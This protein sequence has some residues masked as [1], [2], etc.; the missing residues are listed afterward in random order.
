VPKTTKLL[1]LLALIGACAT[2]KDDPPEQVPEP[3]GPPLKT[4]VDSGPPCSGGYNLYRQGR[5]IQVQCFDWDSN[6]VYDNRGTLTPEAATMLDAEIAAADLDDTEPVNHMGSCGAFDSIGT[7]TLWVGEQS[8]SFESSCLIRGIV[9]L[10]E[11]VSTI[12]A[13]IDTCNPLDFTLL[14]SVE[15]GC[16][17]VF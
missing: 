17:V 3:I 10:Y 4:V 1:L 2:P 11:I 14:E 15:P 6:L 8:I 16:Q 12:E 9:P 7:E 13:E 5:Q